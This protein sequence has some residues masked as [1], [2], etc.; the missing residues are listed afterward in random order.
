MFTFVSLESNICCFCSSSDKVSIGTSRETRYSTCAGCLKPGQQITAKYQCELKERI[1]HQMSTY[2]N[3][4]IGGLFNRLKSLLV[5]VNNGFM[6]NLIPF[7]YRNNDKIF[8][9]QINMS[10]P[11]FNPIMPSFR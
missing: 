11:S 7:I 9:K 8:L 2:F 10:C 3:C 6:F 1:T 4:F 5:K